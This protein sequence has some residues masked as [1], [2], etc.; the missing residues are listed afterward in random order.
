MANDARVK[1]TLVCTEC[2]QRNYDTTKNKKISIY[3]RAEPVREEYVDF[4]SYMTLTVMQDGERVITDA[5]AHEQGGFP[6]AG[7]IE[8]EAAA[9]RE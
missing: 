5:G 6:L 2:K 4:L 1:I 7:V 8:A 9:L 3:M